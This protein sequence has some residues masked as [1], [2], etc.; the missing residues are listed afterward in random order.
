[1]Y[2]IFSMSPVYF[3][4]RIHRLLKSVPY[5]LLQMRLSSCPDR[6]L[7]IALDIIYEDDRYEILRM[8]PGTKKMRVEQERDYLERLKISLKQ[9]QQIAEELA[10]KMEGRRQNTRG[11][12]IAP[13]RARGKP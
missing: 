11:T 6:N 2:I 13:G 5:P 9:K 8:L 10:D 3:D 7:A 4:E 12:W 1:M